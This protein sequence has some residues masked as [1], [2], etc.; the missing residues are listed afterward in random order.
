MILTPALLSIMQVLLLALP[1]YVEYRL[2]LGTSSPTA[3][4]LS[5]LFP[6]TIACALTRPFLIR[7]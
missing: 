2:R 4:W 1:G 7:L 6:G 3:H 5:L